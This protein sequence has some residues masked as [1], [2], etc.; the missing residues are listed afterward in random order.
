MSDVEQTAIDLYMIYTYTP[1]YPINEFA[2][3][4]DMTVE[5]AQ[6]WVAIGHKLYKK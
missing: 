4:I 3:D 1:Y 2:K 5:N 6:A